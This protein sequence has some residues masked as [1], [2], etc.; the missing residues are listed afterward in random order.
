[1]V[2]QQPD[3]RRL[4][5]DSAERVLRRAVELDDVGDPEARLSVEALLEAASDLGMDPSSVQ[6]AVAEE[7]A[8]L[9]EVR[10]SALDRL[11]GPA[12]VSSARLVEVP[13]TE[14]MEVL[15]QWLRRAWAFRRVRGTD[16]EAVYRRRTD[17]VAGIQR[18]ARSL[19]GKENADKLRSVRVSTRSVGPARTLV[20]VVVDLSASRTTAEVG[21]ASVG[22]AGA[23]ASAVTALANTPWLWLGVPASALAG[24]GVM[25]TRRAWTRGVDEVVE[26]LLDR[27][28]A[29]ELPDALLG[30]VAGRL[31]D[32][33]GRRKGPVSR[34][35]G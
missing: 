13:A 11:T 30:E 2:P 1:M 10:T 15:D 27:L 6:R 8:G 35:R 25:A 18:A 7:Q 24:A 19:T 12:V 14:A 17:P 5:R 34:P 32:G 26:G 3:P 4:D 21:G 22:G 29:G 33:L 31:L 9:L 20:A 28:E 16:G 23:L